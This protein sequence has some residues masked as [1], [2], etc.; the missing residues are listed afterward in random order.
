[1]NLYFR[2][3]LQLVDMELV[4]HEAQSIYIDQ[5]WRKT[6]RSTTSSGLILQSHIYLI[7][8][9]AA[10]HQQD[11]MDSHL[12]IRHLNF[13]DKLWAPLSLSY[14]FLHVSGVSSSRD[15]V[16]AQRSSLMAETNDQLRVLRDT[17]LREW[18]SCVRVFRLVHHRWKVKV[19]AASC[20][21]ARA[22]DK[23][24]MTGNL[25]STNQCK[26]TFMFGGELLKFWRSKVTATLT[27]TLFNSYQ[28]NI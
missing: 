5:C 20:V 9:L 8:I 17:S 2:F 22:K 16:T 10:R 27:L 12:Q 14:L 6:K 4:L 21:S 7:T 15:T 25:V 24:T 11:M 28:V 26:P 1:M 18:S 23:T 19:A 3:K 13:I